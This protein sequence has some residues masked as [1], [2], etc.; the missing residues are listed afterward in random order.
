[1]IK[2]LF[3]PPKIETR[4]MY[5]QKVLGIHIDEETINGALVHAK[6]SKNIVEKIIQENIEKGSDD[7]FTQRAAHAITAVIQKA[8]HINEIRACVPSKKVVFKELQLPF[9]DPDKIR[10]IL[11]Y[12]IEP[13]LPFSIDEAVVDFIITKE[14]KHEKSC[15]VLAAAVRNEDLENILEIYKTAKIEPHH[16]SIDLFAVYSLYQQI[17]EYK[18]I[19]HA[20]AIVEIDQHVTHVALLHDGALKLTRVIP[21]GFDYIVDGICKEVDTPRQLVI[22]NIEKFGVYSQAEKTY[23]Q[24]F[25]SFFQ[26]IQFTLSSFLL[27]LG[28]TQGVQKIL[29]TGKYSTLKDLSQFCQHL[30]QIS[31]EKFSCAK[32]FESPHFKNKTKRVATDWGP[33]LICLGLALPSDQQYYFDFRRKKFMYPYENLIKKQ[34][35]FGT[36]LTLAML[37]TIIT[38]GYLHIRDL[39]NTVEE[40]E[41]REL[42]KLKRLWPKT[43]RFKGAMTLASITK[44]AEALI[45]KKQKQWAP[46]EKQKMELLTIL[47]ELTTIMDKRRFDVSVNAVSITEEKEVPKVQVDAFFRSKTGEDHNTFF[48]ELEDRFENSKIL[49]PLDP[50]KLPVDSHPVGDEGI[51]FTATLKQKEEEEYEVVK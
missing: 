4:R 30:L 42:N 3:L 13:M 6:R 33:H 44:K 41:N 21:K 15:Q 29:F 22:D 39:K 25:I 12:E 10:M 48:I 47:S 16:I 23:E 40:I 34:L 37:G 31:S 27:N 36:L 18:A 8:G 19:K 49:V 11:D 32:L 2:Q 9:K 35:I 24:H 50:K 26:D 14:S 51:E 38:S 45:E 43:F 1:M 20:S 28:I 5:G 46:F 17:P 7:S